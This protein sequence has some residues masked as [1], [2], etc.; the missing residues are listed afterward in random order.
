MRLFTGRYDLTRG[1]NSTSGWGLFARSQG[2]KLLAAES[3]KCTMNSQQ[4]ALRS[5]I[6]PPAPATLHVHLA[7]HCAILR[8]SQMFERISGRFRTAHFY[9]ALPE[10]QNPVGELR[11]TPGAPLPPLC[12]H[13]SDVILPENVT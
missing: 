4:L 8:N 2:R 11:Q 9:C 1:I 13:K 6:G 12:H 10:I 7:F 5:V 3:K